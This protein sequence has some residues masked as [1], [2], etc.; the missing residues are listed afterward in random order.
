MPNT[1]KQTLCNGEIV[2]GEAAARVVD[3]EVCTKDQKVKTW[4][5]LPAGFFHVGDGD[6]GGLGGQAME[7]HGG[8]KDGMKGRAGRA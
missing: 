8:W 2:R 4:E 6:F 3:A 5:K 7:R 1:A